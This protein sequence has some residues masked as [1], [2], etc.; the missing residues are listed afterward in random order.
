MIGAGCVAQVEHVPNLLRLAPRF[1]LAGVCDPS[2]TVRSFLSERYGIAGFERVE[3][4]L[5][6]PLDAVLIASPDALHK[7]HTLAAL[8]HG[9]HVLCEKPLCYAA[10]DI[11]ELIAARDA[12]GKVLQV[13]YMKRFD[14]SYQAALE[15]LPGHAAGLRQIAVE[16][17][18]PD[19]LPFT[20]HHAWKSGD[21]VPQALVAEARE[22]QRQQ[23]ARAVGMPLDELGFRGFCGP[24]CSSLVHDVNAVHG[25]LER[26]GIDDEAVVGAHIYA[27]G[28]GGHGAVRLAG[29]RALWTMTHLSLP[30]LA[31]YR[32]RITL[33]FD[34]ASLE[35]EFPSPYLNHQPTRLTLR[36]GRGFELSREDIRI[37]Y[38]EAFI[39]ELEGFWAAI[40]AGTPC[41]NT[42]EQARRDMLL[43][44]GLSRWQASH[45]PHPIAREARA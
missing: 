27:G 17:S 38:E 1:A 32:E 5:A 2:H 13:G 26:L 41:R 37:S 35:L 8:A 23:V 22:K 34:E 18:D 42:A 25:L 29:D 45:Q 12:A 15:L 4:L 7:E 14:P 39:A 11:D 3:E 40:T 6:Q 33:Y 31:D 10:A 28:A 21:D 43:L 24:Y 9:M 36:R 19:A 20:R 44:A 16:V 30:K